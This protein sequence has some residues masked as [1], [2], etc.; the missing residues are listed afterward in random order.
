MHRRAAAL[1]AL[2]ALGL[3]ACG[4]DEDD[5]GPDYRLVTPPR[6]VG[7]PPVRTPEPGAEPR[8]SAADARR[9]RPVIAAWAE[10]VR[11]G[12]PERATRYFALPA[13]VSQPSFGPVV[14]ES[15]EVAQAFNAALPCGAR[16]LATRPQGRYVVG[17][18]RLVD[19]EGKRCP[20]AGRVRVGFVFG[21]PDH[22]RR[23]SEWWQAATGTQG[24]PGPPA[25][26]AAQL[27]G[28]TY[29]G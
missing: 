2:C 15:P 8:P 17:T 26:P 7:A 27:A 11:R 20:S 22:P 14:V 3:G 4:G 25:R 5:G 13:I 12:Q 28:R 19:A 1:A 21:D 18:F 10:A 9:L 24:A 16:L 6:Y 23:F 29:F